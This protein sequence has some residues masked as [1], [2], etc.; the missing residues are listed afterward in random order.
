MRLSI[1]W[2]FQYFTHN[3]SKFSARS[4]HQKKKSDIS[5]AYNTVVS[6]HIPPSL[7]RAKEKKKTRTNIKTVGRKITP[8][9]QSMSKGR[10]KARVFAHRVLSP[11]KYSSAWDEDEIASTQGKG[12]KNAHNN[13]NQLGGPKLSCKINVINGNRRKKTRPSKD[14]TCTARHSRA[15]IGR[16]K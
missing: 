9:T 7:L 15:R 10:A 11:P 3:H 12:Q 4:L 13:H 6:P 16:N 8:K 1:S 2:K 5:F 14:K